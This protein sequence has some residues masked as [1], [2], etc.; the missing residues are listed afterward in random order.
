MDS[1]VE[2]GRPLTPQPAGPQPSAGAQAPK[3][4]RQPHAPALQEATPDYDRN[5]S[6]EYPRRARQLGFEGIVL[7][8]VWVNPDG[9]VDDAKIAASSGYAM[10]DDSALRA[11]KGWMF[12]PARRGDQP[13]AA[14]VQVP[15]R[16]TLNPTAP[17]FP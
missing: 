7:L 12:K 9:G 5:P 14:L 11:V 16:F 13:V 6:P 8:H 15:I 17:D 10:L 1:P 2:D 3:G 4:L